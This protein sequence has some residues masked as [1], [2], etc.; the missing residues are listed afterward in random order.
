[1][2]KNYKEKRTIIRLEEDAIRKP[3]KPRHLGSGFHA[4]GRDRRKNTRANQLQ[5][6]LEFEEQEEQDEEAREL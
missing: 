6:D 3:K 5:A 2:G 4:D 1:M